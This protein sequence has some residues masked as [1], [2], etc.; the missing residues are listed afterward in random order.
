MKN[1][2]NKSLK[3]ELTLSGASDSEAA[4]L[5]AIASNLKQLNNTKRS[6]PMPTLHDQHP[7]KGRKLVLIGGPSLTGLVIGM[8]LIILSQAVLPGS[9]LYPVQKL[10]DHVAVAVNPDYRGIIMMKR[11]QQVKQLVAEH[12][13]SHTVLATLAD[14]QNEASAY[15][16]V[17][18]ADYAA[19]EYCK[20]N[21]QQAA[22]AA[23]N[24]DRQAINTTLSSLNDV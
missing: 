5:V 15:K 14:Y 12:A 19:F 2:A 8:A 9:F 10:S 17:S 4:E 6:V 18:A 13:S 11:A 23:P 7:M 16:S 20:S 21:L 3:K 1:P 22:A 24:P